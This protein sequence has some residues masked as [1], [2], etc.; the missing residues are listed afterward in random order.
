MGDTL[1]TLTGTDKK[2]G[3]HAVERDVTDGP[4]NAVYRRLPARH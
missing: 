4:E 1:F 2:G 3:A